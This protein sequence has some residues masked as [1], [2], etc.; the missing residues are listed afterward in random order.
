ME[1]TRTVGTPGGRKR[2]EDLDIDGNIIKIKL[3]EVV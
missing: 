1:D 2:P 3:E